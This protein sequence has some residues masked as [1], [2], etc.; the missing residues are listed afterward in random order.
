[1][2]LDSVLSPLGPMPEH[3]ADYVA[4]LDDALLFTEG[5]VTMVRLN[6]DKDLW[7]PLDSVPLDTLKRLAIACANRRLQRMNDALRNATLPNT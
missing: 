3:P 6:P 7:Q 5:A 4:L 2:S 1:M